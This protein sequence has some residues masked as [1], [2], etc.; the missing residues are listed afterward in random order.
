MNTNGKGDYYVEP[1]QEVTVDIFR[2]EDAEGVAGCFKTVYGDGYPV[3]AYYEPA[4]L[5]A[6]NAEGRIISTVARTTGGEVVG[7]NAMFRYPPN[8][9][10]YESGAGVV[11]PAY[12][13][14]GL[15]NK[16]VSH[17]T[18]VAAPR[19]GVEMVYGEP[20]CNHVFSQ[21]LTHSQGWISMALEMDL[22][23]AAAYS[24]EKSAPGRV[25]SLLD[26]G[27]LKPCPQQVFLPEV[28]LEELDFLYADFPE[29][30]S[31]TPAQAAP[32]AGS[33]SRVDMDIF[34]FAQVARITVHQ[35]GEDLARV[36]ADHQAQAAQKDCIVFQ[37]RLPLTVPWVGAS[38]EALRDDGWF[39]GGVLPC[40]FAEGDGL[41]MQKMNHTPGWDDMKLEFERGKQVTELVRRDWE[42]TVSG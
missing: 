34:D 27:A 2:P 3:R 14:G 26:F 17:N 21:K 12:R 6:A 30:R 8:A 23:P 42:R 7:H 28:Y 16:M 38:V 37:V 40:W 15:F 33:T 31:F 18:Q 25:S 20:V 36:V 35:V 9:K 41:L 1:G 19:F 24:K 32:P 39:L 13:S 5:I 22:M 29:Q 11:L 10:H 4:E